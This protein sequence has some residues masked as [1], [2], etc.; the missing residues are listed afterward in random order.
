MKESKSIFVDFRLVFSNRN[1][2]CFSNICPNEEFPE[3]THLLFFEDDPVEEELQILVCIVD[4]KLLKTI[5][6]Q[7][8][9]PTTQTQLVR[10][11]VLW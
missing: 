7:V 8:L 4:A 1:E 2:I 9:L 3:G 11:L 10:L 6:G 5:E